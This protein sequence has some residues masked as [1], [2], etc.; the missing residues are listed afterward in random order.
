MKLLNTVLPPRTVA[1]GRLQA[2]VLDWAGTTVDHG[3]LAPARTLQ[4]VFAR[5]GIVLTDSEIRRDM[6]LSK[7]VHIRTILSM[8]KV[9]DAWQALRGPVSADSAEEEIYQ[10]FIPGSRFSQARTEDR[11]V[12]RIHAG[13]ARSA[14]RK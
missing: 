14:A 10:A 5:A 7:K 6:G 9:R 2:L 3:S 12:N 13:N 11:L 8:P 4:Q 1:A